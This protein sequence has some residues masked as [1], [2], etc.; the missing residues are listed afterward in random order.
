MGSSVDEA[1]KV[2]LFC[3]VGVEVGDEEKWGCCVGRF[4]N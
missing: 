1:V 3:F 4:N 2:F